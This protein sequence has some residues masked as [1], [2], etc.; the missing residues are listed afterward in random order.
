M[1]RIS[2]PISGSTSTV[3]ASSAAEHMSPKISTSGSTNTGTVSSNLGEPTPTTTTFNPTEGS[4]PHVELKKTT[5]V[6][7]QNYN[8]SGSVMR[9]RVDQGLPKL[10]LTLFAP[11]GMAEDL[12]KVQMILCNEIKTELKAV[13]ESIATIPFDDVQ[14]KVTEATT[15]LEERMSN[16]EDQYNELK[17]LIIHRTTQNLITDPTL[18]DHWNPVD[19]VMKHS[20]WTS[21]RLVLNKVASENITDLFPTDWH[22]RPTISSVQEKQ[23]KVL[24]E[25]KTEMFQQCGLLI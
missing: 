1:P 19:M 6:A 10:A 17:E 3:T 12:T 24:T 13:K 8:T 4:S 11:V 21:M 2:N 9:K 25:V 22:P 23:Y 14:R 18:L 7:P 16:L 15:M 20:P 5:S